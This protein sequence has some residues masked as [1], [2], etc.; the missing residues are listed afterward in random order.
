MIRSICE[1]L[2]P[3]AAL[4]CFAASL[5]PFAAGRSRAD[6]A[7]V[8]AKPPPI[9]MVPPPAAGL[10]PVPLEAGGVVAPVP[11]DGPVLPP[12][13]E[14]AATNMIALNSATA[15]RVI[16]PPPG[17]LEA[18]AP[19]NAHYPAQPRSLTR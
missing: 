19:R 1:P 2:T 16:C 11:V 18:R 8:S 6:S 10:P 4:S 14:Q 17:A 7:P 15:L 13:V 3:P 12:G 5:A 9:L